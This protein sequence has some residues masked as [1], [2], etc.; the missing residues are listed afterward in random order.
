[1]KE[2][3]HF[4]VKTRNSVDMM[5]LFETKSKLLD[6]HRDA[7]KTSMMSMYHKLLNNENQND[8]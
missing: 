4:L 8:S 3:I 1:M 7:W 6:V 5:S 2:Q